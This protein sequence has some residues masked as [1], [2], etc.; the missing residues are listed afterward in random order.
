M[1]GE[2]VW[3]EE[4]RI[5]SEPEFFFF[6]L[7]LFFLGGGKEEKGR[8]G[9]PQSTQLVTNTNLGIRK[10]KKV[11]RYPEYIVTRIPYFNHVILKY[12]PI[13]LF[14]DLFI[15]FSDRQVASSVTS[16]SNPVRHLSRPPPPREVVAI[17][18]SLFKFFVHHS[19]L[20]PVLAEPYLD[21]SGIK[22][23]WM[24]EH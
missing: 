3:G 21:L 17:F 10:G 1:Y 16:R 11:K 12:I 23:K 9:G 20:L 22:N 18:L 15:F 19:L 6:F 2:I 8:E 24:K 4:N 7:N 5:L 14:I 13:Y